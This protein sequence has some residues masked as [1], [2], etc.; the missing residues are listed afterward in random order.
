MKPSI[1]IVGA[2][3]G[4]LSCALALQRVGFSAQ[5]YDQMTVAS[6][7][8]AGIGL[9]PGAVTSLAEIG[10][11]DW[12]WKLPVCRF[13]RAETCTPDGRVLTG[14]DVS[15]I[16]RGDGFVVRR[17]DLHRALL[18]M[19]DPTRMTL[20]SELVGLGQDRDGVN[21]SF[22]DGS[23]ARFD[24][25]IGADGLRSVVRAALHGAAEPRY[26]GETC[27][28]G[29][30][31]VA[32]EDTG[33]L[34]E[35]QGRGRR[36]AV[37]PLDAGH[38]YWWAAVRTAADGRDAPEQRKEML[39]RAFRGWE[40]G[41]P[42]ALVATPAETI[43]RND[44]FDRRALKKWSAGRVTLL[45]D[46]A[47]PTTPNLGL[48]GCMAIEDALVLA[49]AL[50]ERDGRPE[51]AFGQYER[52]RHRRTAEVVRM[53]AMFGRLGSMTGRRRVRVRE[54]LMSLA[55]TALMARA[56]ARPVSYQPGPLAR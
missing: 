7:V 26:S 27:F 10:I 53:S 43:L 20:G 2:G 49:R 8:G 39:A 21:L 32:V 28:R 23:A 24:L 3:I 40:F 42:E 14:F 44:L 54:D 22:A 9:W 38:V 12:F 37:H 34:R 6:E 19:V 35:V 29:M 46:A 1:A 47:H 51:A 45:G 55:P 4:G 56:F 16:T 52:E 17:A 11:A 48:G 31:A 41:F 18:E 5:V 15:A 36:C 13:Q 50:S 25:V 30:S 33:T